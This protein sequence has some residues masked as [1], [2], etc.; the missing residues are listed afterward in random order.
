MNAKFAFLNSLLDAVQ[1]MLRAVAA[2]QSDD[3]DTAEEELLAVKA[4]LDEAQQELRAA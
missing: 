3:Y 2:L 1:K 4:I